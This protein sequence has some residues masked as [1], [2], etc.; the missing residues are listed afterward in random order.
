[1]FKAESKVSPVH[2]AVERATTDDFYLDV[3]EVMTENHVHELRCRFQGRDPET[4][5]KLATTEAIIELI[6]EGW[7]EWVDMYGTRCVRRLI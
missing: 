3:R 6:A 4:S 7:L 5:D 1:M 2:E